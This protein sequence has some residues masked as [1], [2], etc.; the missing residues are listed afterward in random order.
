MILN[1]VV[2]DA[3]G[4]GGGVGR[5]MWNIVRTSAT[6]ILGEIMI[7]ATLLPPAFPRKTKIE[8]SRKSSQKLAMR[9]INVVV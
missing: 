9:L 8:N 6:V 1:L 3:R 7:P 5:R 4:G 2:G